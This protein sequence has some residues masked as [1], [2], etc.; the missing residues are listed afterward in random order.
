MSGRQL[1][2]DR[3]RRKPSEM[4]EYKRKTHLN[5][6]EL[7]WSQIRLTLVGNVRPLPAKQVNNHRA[8]R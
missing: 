7:V 6:A 3:K 8:T 4:T 2:P 1:E 5:A